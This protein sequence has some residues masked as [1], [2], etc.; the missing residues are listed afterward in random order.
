[1]FDLSQVS[2]FYVYQYTF[3]DDLRFVRE[4]TAELLD[5]SEAESQELIA[6]VGELFRAKGWEGDGKLGVLW[7]PPFLWTHGDTHGTYVWHV[8][9]LNNGISWLASRRPLSFPGIVEQND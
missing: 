8:K 4:P 3:L 6:A 5:A 1:M 7:L 2:K 9:Q